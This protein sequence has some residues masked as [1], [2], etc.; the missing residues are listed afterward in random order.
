MGRCCFECGKLLDAISW[1][2]KIKRELI[3]T[4][5]RIES[6]YVLVKT[7]S[8]HREYSQSAF[9]AFVGDTGTFTDVVTFFAVGAI[10]TPEFC[11]DCTEKLK[12]DL[13][14]SD[15]E[16]YSAYVDKTYFS[17]YA[18][19]LWRAFW[20]FALTVFTIL[21]ILY[22]IV[23]TYN[24]GDSLYWGKAAVFGIAPIL[25]AFGFAGHCVY[26][27]IVARYKKMNEISKDAARKRMLAKAEWRIRR[28]AY[29][30][31]ELYERLL[32]RNVERTTGCAPVSF[33]PGTENALGDNCY[34]MTTPQWR[35]A[36]K[37]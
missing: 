17:P 25:L 3:P 19:E 14:R 32:F 5:R 35:K 33:W 13:I 27:M 10:A 6:E 20:Y 16:R 7:L 11:G 21:S 2:G 36:R 30:K 22:G 9:E 28:F 15:I 29:S 23:R 34:L 12:S 31:S 24:P 18:D 8:A 37:H 26:N 1:C 4:S